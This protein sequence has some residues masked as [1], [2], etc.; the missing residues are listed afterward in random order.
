MNELKKWILFGLAIVLSLVSCFYLQ[1]RY[2]RLMNV[3]Y[4]YQWPVT[5][6]RKVSWIPTD[7]L[8]V[9]FIGSHTLWTGAKPPELNQEIYVI[10]TPRKDGIL[11]VHSATPDK[12]QEDNV[13]IAANVVKYDNEI[14]EFSIPFNRVH[15]NVNQVNPKFYENYKGVLIATMKIKDGIGIITG[16]YSKGVFIESAE[17]ESITEQEK[18]AQELLSLQKNFEK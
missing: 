18:Q 6:E 14:V 8:E 13:Y 10:L 5:L 2:T 3:G 9:K 1:Q 15:V 16:V 17:P 12:P 4:E 7:Y 11:M